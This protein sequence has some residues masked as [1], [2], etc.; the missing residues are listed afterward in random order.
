MF[1]F[2]CASP[3]GPPS[4]LD[5]SV[6]E[7]VTVHESFTVE[8]RGI[9]R[10]GPRESNF[11]ITFPKMVNSNSGGNVVVE[12]RER[13]AIGNGGDLEVRRLGRVGSVSSSYTIRKC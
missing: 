7:T 6:T 3:A 12:T 13:I 5:V 10:A 4:L 8:T 9:D 1:C 11:G 2:S